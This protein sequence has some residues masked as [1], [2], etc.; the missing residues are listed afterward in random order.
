MYVFMFW[1]VSVYY[2]KLQKKLRLSRLSFVF[3]AVVAVVLLLRLIQLKLMRQWSQ[4]KN[5]AYHGFLAACSCSI[6]NN[7]FDKTD[8]L[9]ESPNCLGTPCAENRYRP[10]LFIDSHVMSF[11]KI[12]FSLISEHIFSYWPLG[13]RSISPSKPSES[14]ETFPVIGSFLPSA[15]VGKKTC[16]FGSPEFAQW[17]TTFRSQT[18]STDHMVAQGINKTDRRFPPPKKQE[19]RTYT[20]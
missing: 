19:T 18:T 15:D 13:P 9:C 12:K 3:A 7:Q 14:Q 1:C 16:T 8:F 17:G 4:Q 20:W 5:S 10:G 6:P 2:K 11:D